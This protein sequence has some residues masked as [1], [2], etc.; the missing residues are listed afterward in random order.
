MIIRILF[1]LL[2]TTSVAAQQSRWSFGLEFNARANLVSY[3]NTANLDEDL[4][5]FLKKEEQDQLKFST[6]ISIYTNYRFQDNF[7]LSFGMGMH[8]TGW[9]SPKYESGLSA[10]EIAGLDDPY[11]AFQ[12]RNND[13]YLSV[14]VGIIYHIAPFFDLEL[15]MNY[16]YL[17]SRKQEV[18]K[19]YDS[20][21]KREVENYPIESNKH[22]LGI[23]F[24]AYYNYPLYSSDLKFGI[25]SLASMVN[26]NGATD[27][28][29][30]FHQVGLSVKYQWRK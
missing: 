9:K 14:P 13:Y 10:E 5:Q 24:G 26:L 19:W 23:N 22:F 2:I 3:K 18:K 16:A 29:R 25:S 15:G 4:F 28:G 12:I 7:S 20:D 8:Q 27:L 11:S 6:P 21:S 30:T 17:V 1:L